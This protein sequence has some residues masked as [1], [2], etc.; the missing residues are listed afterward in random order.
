MSKCVFWKKARYLLLF[1]LVLFLSFPTISIFANDLSDKSN[2]S[3]T[4]TIADKNDVVEDNNIKEEHSTNNKELTALSDT[5]ES[6]TDQAAATDPRIVSI[7]YTDEDTC[8][9]VFAWNGEGYYKVYTEDKYGNKGTEYEINDNIIKIKEL[10]RGDIYTLHIVPVDTSDRSKDISFKFLAT[11]VFAKSTENNLAELT[12]VG[13]MQ[14]SD[15]SKYK[16]KIYRNDGGTDEIEWSD[17]INETSMSVTL[18]NG[19]VTGLDNDVYYRFSVIYEDAVTPMSREVTIG[20]LPADVTGLKSIPGNGSILLRWDASDGATSYEIRRNDGNVFRTTNT[21]Y[22]DTYNI[23]DGKIYSYKVIATRGTKRSQ[24]P[25]VITGQCKRKGFV[26]KNQYDQVNLVVKEKILT[27]NPCYTLNQK[28]TVKGLMLHS[29]GT[30]VSSADVFTRSWNTPKQDNAC[31]HAFIDSNT[32]EVHQHLPWNHRG[33][34]AGG[35]ANNTHIGVEMC[36]SQAIRY[37]RGSRFT[38]NNF[39][40]ARQQAKTAYNAAVKLFAVLCKEYNLDPLASGVIISHSEGSRRGVASAHA[41]P[42]HYW[43]Q[44]GLGY[45]MNGFRRDVY[46]LLNTI[47]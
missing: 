12:W 18:E 22:N 33:W 41:D 4:E 16:V 25:A 26:D 40:L 35:R 9:M 6:I 34:H 3:E 19:T 17:F 1:S 10:K 20:K 43:S 11:K 45:T 31:V 39:P 28:I 27:R 44:L 47:R 2:H 24:H 15:L 37:Y 30:P 13:P 8:S 23:Q 21:E 7:Y 14:A 46:N 38:C 32:G 5:T 36:E 29:V 42:E